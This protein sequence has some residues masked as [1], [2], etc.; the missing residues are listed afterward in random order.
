MT[1]V[2][3]LVCFAVA[4]AAAVL[5]AADRAHSLEPNDTTLAGRPRLA[6]GHGALG[7]AST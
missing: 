5:V 2:A 3:V 6:A 1:R 7:S 4:L